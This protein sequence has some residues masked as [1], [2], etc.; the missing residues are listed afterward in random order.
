M[1]AVV[2]QLVPPNTITFARKFK[3]TA[4]NLLQEAILLVK[5]NLVEVYVFN[6]V[7]EKLLLLS[8]HA[9]AARIESVQVLSRPGLDDLVFLSFADCKVNIGVK[10]FL[11]IFVDLLTAV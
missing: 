8:K 5:T 4:Q 9:L 6:E 2:D 1:N 10:S 11:L 3:L 7:M